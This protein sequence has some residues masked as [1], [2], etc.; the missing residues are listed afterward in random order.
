MRIDFC[1]R[2]RRWALHIL[3]TFTL[4]D[5]LGIGQSIKRG[6]IR[7]RT[8]ALI[9]KPLSLLLRK[10]LPDIG[11]HKLF[12]HVADAAL[13]STSTEVFVLNLCGSRLAPSFQRYFTP[14]PLPRPVVVHRENLE[15]YLPVFFGV[16]RSRH[17]HPQDAS[18]HQDQGFAAPPFPQAG[19]CLASTC[20]ALLVRLR[21]KPGNRELG[22]DEGGHGMA[23]R[24]R[25]SS[26][27]PSF[28]GASLV[29]GQTRG[30]CW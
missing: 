20:L 3:G 27:A 7:Y 8:P 12:F 26:Q 17:Q 2:C 10:S 11:Q 30:C 29:P 15:E 13:E 25:S 18:S 14:L 5:A 28:Q 16:A 22:F 23:W 19:E 24:N 4:G 6:P 21:R 9:V 1:P